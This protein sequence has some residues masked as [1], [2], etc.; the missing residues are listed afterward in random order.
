MYFK[1]YPMETNELA[2]RKTDHV[3]VV[4][5]F[6]EDAGFLLVPWEGER[7]CQAID[8]SISRIAG[9]I[10]SDVSEVLERIYKI[11]KRDYYDV[12]SVWNTMEYDNPWYDGLKW[13]ETREEADAEMEKIADAIARGDRLYDLTQE[14]AHGE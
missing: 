4:K 5:L 8:A 6:G 11:Q 7:L 2:V 3:R 1:Y 13:Y 10:S 9:L 14:A 12:A